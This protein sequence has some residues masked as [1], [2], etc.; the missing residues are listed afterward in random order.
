MANRDKAPPG[1]M[2]PEELI[3]RAALARENAYA[4]YSNYLVGAALLTRSGQVYLGANVENAVYSLTVCAERTAV[5]KAISEGEREFEAIAVVTSNG[6]SPCGACRQ[7]LR[8][9]APDLSV[10]IADADG[11]YRQTSVAELL[12]DSFGPE[13]LD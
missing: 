13:F 2:P 11:N 7:V 3:A 12:P 8:E 1:R 9:F 10:Y 6:G 4:P 5:F